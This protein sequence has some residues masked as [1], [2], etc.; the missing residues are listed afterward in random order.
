MEILEIPTH[1]GSLKIKYN[2]HVKEL[3]TVQ[4]VLMN[5]TCN[6]HQ[7]YVGKQGWWT[8]TA[9]DPSWDVV[10]LKA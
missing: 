7:G 5:C 2:M 9:E 3:N 6:H 1:Q 8:N 10:G 4:L